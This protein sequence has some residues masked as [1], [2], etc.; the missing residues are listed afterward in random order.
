MQDTR[1]NIT[2]VMASIESQPLPTSVETDSVLFEKIFFPKLEE[3]SVGI[4]LLNLF[5]N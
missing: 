3:N 1:D 2:A 5:F 4:S